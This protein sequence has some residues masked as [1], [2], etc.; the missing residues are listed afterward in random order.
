LILD[1]TIDSNA[2]GL[3]TVSGTEMVNNGTLRVRGEGS[4]LSILGSWTNHGQI[5]ASGAD[6]LILSD[7]DGSFENLGTIFA[8]DTDVRLGGTF[9]LADLGDF[10]FINSVVAIEGT[11]LNDAG[12]VVDAGKFHWRLG[13]GTILGGTV[14]S[15][16][17][18][19]FDTVPGN[20]CG[21]ATLDA[22]TLDANMHVQPDTIVHINNGL[23]LNST[24]S[25]HTIN[26]RYSIIRVQGPNR[27]IEGTGRI[28]FA[29]SG[30]NQLIQVTTSQTGDDGLLAI[31][32]DVTIL[33]AAGTVG[34]AG[35]QHAAAVASEGTIHSDR[36]GIIRIQ[37]DEF[38]NLGTVRSSGGGQLWVSAPWT[39]EGIVRIEPGPVADVDSDFTQSP[40]G[41]FVSVASTTASGGFGKMVVDGTATLGGTL[42]LE[43]NEGFTP[44]AGQSF[45]VMQYGSRLGTFDLIEVPGL[46]PSLD[47]IAN[48][49]A[50][51]VTLSVVAK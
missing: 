8:E 40:L 5:E 1:G 33:G 27:F 20:C 10:N 42:R 2:S 51:F 7:D 47:V 36:P 31:G 17:G 35:G 29:T 41:T 48:Y 19:P 18:T 24:I 39:N 4:E 23:T 34:T 45:T 38:F 37:G 3:I 9:T 26:P 15:A 14:A 25:L 28:V 6:T 43:I 11:L 22:V 12:L 16:D 13:R 32:P 50:P 21:N 46:S 30:A 49:D 44:A